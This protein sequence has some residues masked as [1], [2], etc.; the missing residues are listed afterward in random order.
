[1]RFNNINSTKFFL[2]YLLTLSMLF[3][4]SAGSGESDANSV[5]NIEPID[6]RNYI[7]IKSV[8]PTPPFTPGAA[9]L[10]VTVS[11]KLLS[12]ESGELNIGFNDGDNISVYN[13]ID[14][15][16]R[17]ITAG[18][19]EYTFENVSTTV[20]DWGVQGDFKVYVNIG[21]NAS[22]PLDEDIMILQVQ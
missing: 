20:K 7:I 21:E 19:G 16:K 11:Y 8:E 5:E 9:I 15:S 14:S 13:I 18:L 12:L 17:I 6:F 2:I 1:M 4:C 22:N 10:N 3:N